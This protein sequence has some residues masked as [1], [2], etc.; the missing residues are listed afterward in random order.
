M[1]RIGLGQ[2]FKRFPPKR[3]RAAAPEAVW[4]PGIQPLFVCAGRHERDDGLEPWLVRCGRETEDARGRTTHPADSFRIHIRAR[5]Q[6]INHPRGVARRP[7]ATEH[8]C[9]REPFVEVEPVGPAF[10]VRVR[11]MRHAE[12]RQ[13]VAFVDKIGAPVRQFVSLERAE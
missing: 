9:V 5:D 2:S 6:V 10:W 7:Q 12:R 8:V 1:N 3:I 4:L 13:H 11:G